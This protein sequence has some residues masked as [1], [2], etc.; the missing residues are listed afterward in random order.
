[1]SDCW[2]LR[3]TKMVR[4]S[5]QGGIRSS[6]KIWHCLKHT[7]T[8]KTLPFP[9]GCSWV[10]IRG[11]I[12]QFTNHVTKPCSC[13]SHLLLSTFCAHS[14]QNQLILGTKVTRLIITVFTGVMRLCF[15]GLTSQTHL[16]ASSYPPLLL[17]TQP[18]L[19]H[20][21]SGL[22]LPFFAGFS[23]CWCSKLPSHTSH[24]MTKSEGSS[25]T[26]EAMHPKGRPPAA[27]SR[28]RE[29]FSGWA[30]WWGKAS[31]VS[32]HL[33]EICVGVSAPTPDE[34]IN[35]QNNEWVHFLTTST[36]SSA[37]RYR[38]ACYLLDILSSL[39]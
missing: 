6:N 10:K 21:G 33:G 27:P 5:S 32:W 14:F 2:F 31:A 8:F 22:S 35:E 7:E 39:I 24:L 34:Q 13:M 20:D 11:L 25:L 17:L 9:P 23:S 3:G 12:Y 1:M 18:T 4:C 38:A 15:A 26:G 37:G 19:Q 28:S 36:C 16:R 30:C 29:G